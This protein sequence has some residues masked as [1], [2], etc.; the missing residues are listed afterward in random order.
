MMS[1]CSRLAVSAPSAG[2]REKDARTNLCG[3]SMVFSVSFRWNL[4]IRTEIVHPCGHVSKWEHLSVKGIKSCQRNEAADL[5][6]D[7]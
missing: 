1:P 3:G 4:L 7:L 2:K 5:Q 6:A